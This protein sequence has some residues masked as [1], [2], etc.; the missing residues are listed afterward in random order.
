MQLALRRYH[1]DLGMT[2]SLSRPR[3][4]RCVEARPSPASVPS[5]YRVMRGWAGLGQACAVGIACNMLIAIF[6]S[7]RLVAQVARE[8]FREGRLESAPR[9]CRN[10]ISTR[11]PFPDLLP[12][13]TRSIA[14]SFGG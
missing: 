1:G 12:P 2:L 8:K 5:A 9:P 13:S 7:R 10:R 4:V 14:G 6:L 11:S 3:I